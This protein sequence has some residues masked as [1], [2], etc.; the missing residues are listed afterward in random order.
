MKLAE[1]LA[2]L[3]AHVP[4]GSI[5]A[6]IGTDH[7]RLPV[8]LVENGICPKVIASDLN[9]GPF[10]SAK[11]KVR[12]R[13]LEDRIDLRF[14][15][16]L[17]VLKPGEAGVVVVAGMGGNTIRDILAA[18]P[19]VLRG[20][21]RLVLQPMADAGSLRTWLTANRWRIAD[22]ELV[23]EDGRIY[24]VMVAEPGPETTGDPFLL[25][26][27]PRLLEKKDPLL[28]V[29]LAGILD[30]YERMLAGL[31]ASGSGEA[32]KKAREVELKIARLREVQ[33]CL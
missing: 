13:G 16:G 25:E 21:N 18:S 2:V 27:G 11:G 8:F 4:P 15:N 3:A 31:S 5:A 14:G 28:P 26:L 7:A 33:K 17:A 9:P 6:D 30:K 20:I 24:L 12:E 19:E 1:R 10:Q 23:E 22:E 32:R 29:Y